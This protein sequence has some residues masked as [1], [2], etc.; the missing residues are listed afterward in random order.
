MA[1]AAPMA[2]IV[3][4]R[5][6]A[7][8]Q[9]SIH[10]LPVIYIVLLLLLTGCSA[11]PDNGGWG[12]SSDERA[13][14]E[15][16][17]GKSRPQAV[18]SAAAGLAQGEA[19]IALTLARLEARPEGVLRPE[20]TGYYMDVQMATLRKRFV[21]VDVTLAREGDQLRLVLPGSLTFTSGSADLTDNAEAML[22]EVAKVL[23]EYDK[24]LVV[25]EG[26]SD[27]LGAAGFNQ[28]LSEQ[29]A[30]S[31]ARSLLGRG[32]AARRLVAIGYGP[33]YPVASNETEEGRARNRRVELLVRPV[34]GI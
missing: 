5:S 30:L 22:G 9:P 15:A 6:P 10:P 27:A 28:T 8:Q 24:T 16:R 20:Q 2:D 3:P 17:D 4:F 19:A 12:R 7:L 34:T 14:V 23:A 13:P 26:H 11:L 29:R 33:D 1:G 21:G 32:V 25:V 18:A 31:V